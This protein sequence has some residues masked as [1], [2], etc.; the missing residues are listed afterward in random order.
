MI[1]K[2]N[3]P[4]SFSQGSGKTIYDAAVIGGGLAGLSLSIQLAKAGYKVVLIEKEKY[5]FHKVC[6]E[7]ISMESWDFIERL[8]LPL[9]TMNLPAIKKLIVSCPNGK[10]IK[11]DLDIGGFGISRYLLDNELYKIAI[12]NDVEVFEE[13]KVNDVFFEND[14]F[15]ITIAAFDLQ[16]KI[17]AGTFGKRSNLDIRWARRFIKQKPNKLNNYIGVKYHIQTTFLPET[18]ALHNFK[19]GYCGIS[20][21][22]DDK[23]CL[24]YLTTAENLKA[25]NNS[26]SDMEKN[27]LQKN[28]FLKEIF[29][30]AKFLYSSPLTISQI[31]FDKKTPVENHILMIGD[32]AGM[33]TP[34]CGNGM[35]MAFHAG[36]LAFENI[37]KFL[38]NEVS[39]KQM[40]EEYY[41]QWNHHFAKRLRT[42]RLIQKFFGKIWLTNM[43][44][45]IIKYFPFIIRRLI[46]STHGKPF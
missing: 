34:L 42:G 11:S 5:P 41:A 16:A 28:P 10:K 46:S 14:V 19:N 36:K 21:I 35:S 24:C 17:V 6:G 43:F 22:E 25:N 1:H 4:D 33:I 37:D 38:K 32:A 9:S 29:S 15:R 39:R 23:Y 18:I 26:I 7:Y 3:T 44:I 31:S 20:K 45:G 2:K 13:T 40:E 30:T 8:G 27:V 12:Q